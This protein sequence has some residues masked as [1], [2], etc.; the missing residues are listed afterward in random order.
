MTTPTWDDLLDQMLR[1]LEHDGPRAESYWAQQLSFGPVFVH[2]LGLRLRRE[3]AG[4]GGHR[5][6]RCVE[7]ARAG[8]GSLPEPPAC[9]GTRLRL[10]AARQARALAW[11][12]RATL[13]RLL[14]RLGAVAPSLDITAPSR[15]TRAYPLIGFHPQERLAG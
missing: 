12:R 4:F 5:L 15:M 10:L 11:R 13:D 1:E 2:A 3:P 14:A 8:L 9:D 6:R 7:L